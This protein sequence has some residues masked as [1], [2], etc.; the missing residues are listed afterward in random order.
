VPSEARSCRTARGSPI[1]CSSVR[2]ECPTVKNSLIAAD[3]HE[4]IAQA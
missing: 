3:G 4:V 2:M 1:N